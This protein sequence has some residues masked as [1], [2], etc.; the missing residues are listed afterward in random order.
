MGANQCPKISNVEQNYTA[1][2]RPCLGIT[3]HL[4]PIIGLA[5]SAG[6]LSSTCLFNSVLEKLFDVKTWINRMLHHQTYQVLALDDIDKRT[7][8]RIAKKTRLKRLNTN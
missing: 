4:K 1:E 6:G 8:H 7:V 5:T 3:F 2:K